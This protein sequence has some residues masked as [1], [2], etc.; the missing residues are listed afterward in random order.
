MGSLGPA[1]IAVPQ[2]RHCF[3]FLVSFHRIP[4]TLSP[5]SKNQ[6]GTHEEQHAQRN[7]PNPIT[8]LKILELIRKCT[9]LRKYKVQT[10]IV[11]TVLHIIYPPARRILS[12]AFVRST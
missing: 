3:L 8:F 6:L 2:S 10:V 4:Q 7:K 9:R 5:P 1:G 12:K 11:H